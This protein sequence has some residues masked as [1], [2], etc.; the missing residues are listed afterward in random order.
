MGTSRRWRFLII[1]LFLLGGFCAFLI[2]ANYYYAQ[3]ATY[4]LERIRNMPLND[5]ATTELSNSINSKL[6]ARY[7]VS[8]FLKD[9]L[10]QTSRQQQG[11]ERKFDLTS[12]EY[13]P[14]KSHPGYCFWNA[15]KV[16]SFQARVS[17]DIS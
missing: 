11:E 7:T 12:C 8:R 6:S 16:R 15:D 17:S 9:A 14:V 10:T 3:R 2:G 1:P 13:N 5:S 4:L